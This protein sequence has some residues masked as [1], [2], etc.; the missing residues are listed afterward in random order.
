MKKILSVILA[1]I[2]TLSVASITAFAA[3]D[4][5]DFDG[6][7][8]LG[9]TRPVNLPGL[10]QYSKY[11]FIQFVPENDGWYAISS[12]SRENP[13][14][15]PYLELYENKLGAYEVK[16]DDADSSTTDFYLEYYF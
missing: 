7:I 5:A 6:I 4:Y 2:M 9:E 15:D 1:L 11:V 12:D 10:T 8:T 16:V 14:S 3:D 13:D